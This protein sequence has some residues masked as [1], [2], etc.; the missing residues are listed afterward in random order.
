MEPAEP[1][2]ESWWPQEIIK[3]TYCRPNGIFAELATET[4]VEGGQDMVEEPQDTPLK[5]S[6]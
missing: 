2:W 4:E 5:M 6:T 1:P 3:K